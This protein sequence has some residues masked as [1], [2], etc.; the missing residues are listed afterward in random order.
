MY[1]PDIFKF[2]TIFDDPFF[3]KFDFDSPLTLITATPST[4]RS[5]KTKLAMPAADVKETDG[6]YEFKMDLPGFAKEDVEVWVENGML[7]V[8]AEKKTA[9][10]E[11]NDEGNFIRKERYYGT[12]SRSFK[13]DASVDENGI[14][15]SYA[16][17]V[18]TVTAQK[19]EKEEPEKKLIEIK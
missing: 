16:D 3:T 6:A 14:A 18:L 1:L 8:K 4:A 19:T 13:L 11:K 9:D 12:V 10:E 15:A 2:K 5:D 7:N 17:G